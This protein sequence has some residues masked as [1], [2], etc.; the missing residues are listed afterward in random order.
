M[1]LNSALYSSDCS[2]YFAPKKFNDSPEYLQEMLD[3]IDIRKQKVEFAIEVKELYRFTPDAI[4][5]DVNEYFEGFWREWIE[6]A[7]EMQLIPA[8]TLVRYKN[9]YFSLQVFIYGVEGDATK[10]KGTVVKYLF[11]NYTAQVNKH[12][13]CQENEKKE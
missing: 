6:D 7:Y 11:Y 12:I 1:L 10:L 3:K 5:G 8:Q 9:N 4:A 2:P 13:Q